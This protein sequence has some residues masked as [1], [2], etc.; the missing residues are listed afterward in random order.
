MVELHP[1]GRPVK[2]SAF[3]GLKAQGGIAVTRSFSNVGKGHLLDSP[4]DMERPFEITPQ[5]QPEPQPQ[6]APEPQ[7]QPSPDPEPQPGLP[8]LVLDGAADGA[9]TVRNQGTAPAGSFTVYVTGDRIEARRVTFEGLAAGATTAPE[10]FECPIDGPVRFR[11]DY[12]Q[13][14]E[15]SDETNN[16]TSVACR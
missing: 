13:E 14:V 12:S 2:G 7:P 9:F 15:E 11:V 5:A 3:T 10:S 8:D 1:D 6:P 4:L 16:D